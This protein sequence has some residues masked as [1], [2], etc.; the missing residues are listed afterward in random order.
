MTKGDKVEHLFLMDPIETVLV[1]KDSTFALMLEAQARGH[2]VLYALMPDLYMRE[3]QVRV[4]AREARVQPVQG[5]HAELSAPRDVSLDA[6]DVVWMRKDPPFDMGYIVNTYLLELAEER[7]TLVL[8]RP[9]GLRSMNEKAWAMRFPELVPTSLIT[10]DIKRIRAFADEL[11]KIVV[12]PLD[13]NGGE[14]V[15]VVRNDDP[16]IGV[17]LEASTQHGRRKVLA[18]TYLPEIKAGDKRIILV[19]G[20][21][22]GAILRVPQGVDH[23]GN[24]HVGAVVVKTTITE[25]EREICATI[26]PFLKEAGQVF[27]G[28]DVIGDKLTEVN[29]TSPTGIHEIRRFDGVDIAA[30][31]ID[32]AEIRR[33]AKP[34]QRIRLADANRAAP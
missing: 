6:V 25:R 15:F 33:E 9:T 29:V 19:E 2:R 1:D 7:G 8:N 4:T 27:T 14:G 18:Q 26:G 23:R 28:I 16:N 5:A 31:L 11:G 12:K 30:L 3:G 21:P 20:E 24:I 17:I 32:A 34:T 22:V 10:Q 13:G